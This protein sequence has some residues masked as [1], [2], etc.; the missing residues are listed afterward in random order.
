MNISA[1]NAAASAYSVT[2]Q[3]SK[4]AA[5][6]QNSNAGQAGPSDQVILSQNAKAQFNRYEKIQSDAQAMFNRAAEKNFTLETPSSVSKL[7]PDNQDLFDNLEKQGK[8]LRAKVGE[9]IANGGNPVID[10]NLQNQLAEIGGKIAMLKLYGDK[11]VLSEQDVGDKLTSWNIAFKKMTEYV[12]QNEPEEFKEMKSEFQRQMQQ[13]AASWKEYDRTHKVEHTA[14]DKSFA[15][16]NFSF[17]N[18]ETIQETLLKILQPD[19]SK[20]NY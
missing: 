1:V 13:T 4:V 16:S 10:N 12:S 11:E 14:E 9:N 2:N 8:I 6:N 20:N 18:N 19:T 15:S 5:T 17:S 7:L 3:S